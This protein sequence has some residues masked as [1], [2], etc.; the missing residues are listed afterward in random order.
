MTGIAL[1]ESK[2]L[3]YFIQKQKMDRGADCPNRLSGP[4]WFGL[5]LTRCLLVYS[6]GILEVVQAD[7]FLIEGR[8]LNAALVFGQM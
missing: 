8:Q 6:E 2:A 7:K 1:K 5:P 3:L 4:V